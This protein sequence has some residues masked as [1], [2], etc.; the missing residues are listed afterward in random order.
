MEKNLKSK[1]DF[2]EK[3][4]SMK[5]VVVKSDPISSQVSRLTPLHLNMNN[6]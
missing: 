5:P 1:N 3:D 4:V 6:I 2:E